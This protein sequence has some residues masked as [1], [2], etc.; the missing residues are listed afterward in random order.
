MA[1]EEGGDLPED[2]NHPLN[3]H[4]PEEVAIIKGMKESKGDRVYRMKKER[5]KAKASGAG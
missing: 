5:E 3:K 4:W 2:P 1:W